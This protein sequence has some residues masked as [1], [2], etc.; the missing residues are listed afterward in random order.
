MKGF[1]LNALFAAAIVFLLSAACSKEEVVTDPVKDVPRTA[2]EILKQYEGKV[3]SRDEGEPV[4]FHFLKGIYPYQDNQLSTVGY[5]DYARLSRGQYVRFSEITEQSAVLETWGSRIDASSVCPDMDG[6]TLTAFN[7]IPQSKED[8]T[9]IPLTLTESVHGIDFSGEYQDDEIKISLVGTLANDADAWW[10]EYYNTYKKEFE[11]DPTDWYSTEH[12]N[13]KFHFTHPH[14]IYF[15]IRHEFKSNSVI[16]DNCYKNTWIVNDSQCDYAIKE[17]SISPFVFTCP[18]QY[19]DYFKSLQFALNT[20][21][22]NL[23]EYGFGKDNK[24]IISVADLYRFLFFETN[25]KD[26]LF[27]I[28]CPVNGLDEWYYK[29]CFCKADLFQNGAVRYYPLGLEKYLIMP[30][31]DKILNIKVL[32]E[33]RNDWKTNYQRQEKFFPVE[34]SLLITVLEDALIAMEESSPNGIPVKIINSDD[35]RTYM[36]DSPAGSSN[37]IRVLA[38]LL[39][40]PENLRNLN[41]AWLQNGVSENEIQKLNSDLKALG[42]LSADA[43]IGFVYRSR[44]PHDNYLDSPESVALFPLFL[45]T[46]PTL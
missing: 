44:P 24:N 34:E 27:S 38:D 35:I 17:A 7:P 36:I 30:D 10:I 39:L 37:L 25:C 3:I 9:R 33:Y 19:A 23:S 40:R 11:N 14:G 16:N 6:G 28:V 29:E 21:A 15:D 18:D 12:V 42:N 5:D 41:N 2:Y 31:A 1:K 26:G 46:D 13:K 20:P 8:V 43:A 22:L 32:Y 4:Y 45:S